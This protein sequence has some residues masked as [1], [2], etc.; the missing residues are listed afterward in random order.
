MRWTMLRSGHPLRAVE[1]M[2]VG[3][4]KG[5]GQRIAG[6][7]IGLQG[8]PIDKIAAALNG[9]T[10]ARRAIEPE[11]ERVYGNHGGVAQ[12]GW[13]WCS[14]GHYKQR[15]ALSGERVAKNIAV[16]CDIAE[17]HDGVG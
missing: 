9:V 6:Q 11:T 8:D 17:V 10:L 14:A 2:R 4:G 7:L 15:D 16:E 3:G 13:Q 5:D 1:A 12:T